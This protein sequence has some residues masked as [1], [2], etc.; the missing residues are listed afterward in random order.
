MFKCGYFYYTNVL[1]LHTRQI[2]V[3]FLRW[4]YLNGL[5]YRRNNEHNLFTTHACYSDSV[6]IFMSKL[7]IELQNFNWSNSKDTF[8]LP[9]YPNY[10]KLSQRDYPVGKG[11]SSCQSGLAGWAENLTFNLDKL[12]VRLIRFVQIRRS[13]KETHKYVQWKKLNNEF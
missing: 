3:S 12:L 5:L 1:Y 6:W 11:S 2:Y 10:G 9:K 4:F 7:K 13:K 8:C